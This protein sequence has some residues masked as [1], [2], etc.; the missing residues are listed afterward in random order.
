MTCT[1]SRTVDLVYASHT[2]ASRTC[3]MNCEV[4]LHLICQSM[5]LMTVYTVVSVGSRI[6]HCASL[7][8]SMVHLMHMPRSAIASMI[9]R[10][11]KVCTGEPLTWECCKTK[12]SVQRKNSPSMSIRYARHHCSR[13]QIVCSLLLTVSCDR[14]VLRLANEQQQ[15][16]TDA[17]SESHGTSLWSETLQA[18]G[19]YLH[20]VCYMHC[21]L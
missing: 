1:Y 20:V 6:L 14:E 7:G 17:Q 16:A 9:N 4:L 12:F 2:Y 11:C 18:K 10:F 5:Q 15:L 19:C 21:K 3:S 8:S 13:H